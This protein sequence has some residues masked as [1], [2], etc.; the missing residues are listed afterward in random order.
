MSSRNVY[1]V[2]DEQ[3]SGGYAVSPLWPLLALMFAGGW[4]AWPWAIL[5]SYWLD[6]PTRKHEIYWAAFGAVGSMLIAAAI[7]I[8][9]NEAQSEAD[10]VVR[11]RYALIALS[12]FKLAVG[13]RIYMLQSRTLELF[14]FYGGRLRNA[15]PIVLLGFVFRSTVAGL[16]PMAFLRLAFTH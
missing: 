11:L 3:R 14:E 9:S 15:L 7:L 13:Y 1:E 5:N 2:A 16:L 8:W 6:S 12:V 10:A 4:M